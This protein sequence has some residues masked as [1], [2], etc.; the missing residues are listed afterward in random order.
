M[1]ILGISASPRPWGNT[2]ILVRQALSGAREA[3]AGTEFVRLAEL[4]LLPCR[5]CMSCVFKDRDCVIED[6]YHRVLAAMRR[7]DAVVLGSPA[8]ILGATAR[9]KL[10]QER[11]LRAATSAREFVGRP[12]LAVGAAGQPGY[13]PFTLPQISMTFLSLGMPVVDQFIGYGQGPGEV[14]WD[15]AAMERAAAGGA[16]L[17]RGETAFSGEPGACPSC[18]FDLLSDLAFGDAGA[19]TSCPLCDLPGT[20]TADG[21]LEPGP[22]AVARWAEERVRHHFEDRLLPSRDRFREQRQE[23][24]ARVDAFRAAV[25]RA[26]SPE[27][28]EEES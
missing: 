28:L 1:R 3:G 23:I 4:E 15:V 18:H 22:G 21:R 20:R 14:L 16:A 13:V 26:E 24:R 12:G 6:G 7:A 9:V 8:Y 11:L 19:T 10:L 25:E 27:T 5:G 17:A 2:E